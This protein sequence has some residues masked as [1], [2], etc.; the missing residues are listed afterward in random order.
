VNINEVIKYL[1][2]PVGARKNAKLNS[3]E[4]K[5]EGFRKH[6]NRIMDSGLKISQKINTV[7]TFIAS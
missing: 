1:E 4:S 5:V 3:A 6:L 7:K 2:T